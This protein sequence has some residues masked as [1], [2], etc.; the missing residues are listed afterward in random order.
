MDI[1][2]VLRGLYASEI[3]ASVSWFWDGCFDWSLGDGKNGVLFHG[4]CETIEDVATALHK[5]ALKH[6]PGSVY[7]RSPVAPTAPVL[8]EEMMEAVRQAYQHLE[9]TFTLVM[10]KKGCPIAA[11]LRAV[12][13]WLGEAPHD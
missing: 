12:F 8:T 9:K 13:P 5:A 2:T 10:G 7:A 3:N 6:Y 4:T 1:G 11:K